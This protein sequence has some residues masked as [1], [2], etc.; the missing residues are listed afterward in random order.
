VYRVKTYGDLVTSISNPD[1]IISPQY[2][3]PLN[4]DEP[5]TLN[6]PMPDLTQSMTVA[7][8]I[9]LVTFLNSRYRL[10]AQPDYTYPMIN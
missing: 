1:H 6:S 5:G 4:E 10:K 7:E 8:L 2:L 3:G 9:D